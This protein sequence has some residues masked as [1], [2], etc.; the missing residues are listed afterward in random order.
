MTD[1]LPADPEHLAAFMATLP[2]RLVAHPELDLLSDFH[3]L[4]L[5]RT[6]I[7]AKTK[8]RRDLKLSQVSECVA[9]LPQLNQASTSILS[10]DSRK[11]DKMYKALAKLHLFLH[12]NASHDMLIQETNIPGANMSIY[13]LGQ[14][15]SDFF[16]YGGKSVVYD[17]NK[18]YILKG[19]ASVL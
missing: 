3:N 19:L 10:S 6:K 14:K 5:I 17:V 18:P 7:D 13:Q 11:E 15:W 1:K 8:S 12:C 16:K 9:M 2:S 4:N